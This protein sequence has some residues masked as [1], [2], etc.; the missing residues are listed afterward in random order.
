MRPRPR[1]G[2]KLAGCDLWAVREHANLRHMHIRE[3]RD[4]VGGSP[5]VPLERPWLFGP[6]IAPTAVLSNGVIGGAL[7]YMPRRQGVGPARGAEIIGLLNLPAMIYFLWSP[8]TDFWIRRRSWLMVA[9]T[10]AAAAMLAAFREPSLASHWAVGLMFLSACLGQ[11]IVAGCGGM[12][13]TLHSEAA[14]SFYQSGSLAFGAI[15]VLVL[16]SL[17]E[18]LQLGMLGWLVGAMIALPSLAALAAPEQSAVGEFGMG[19]TLTQIW[20]EFKA[21][22]LR[23]RAIPSTLLIVFPLGSGA[24]I[25]LLPGL[26]V[27][28][29]ISGHQVAW[30]NGVAGALLM[31]AGAVSATLISSEAAE[32]HRGS[33]P[34]RSPQAC[35]LRVAFPIE[36]AWRHF[37]P[38]VTNHSEREQRLRS[39]GIIEMWLSASGHQGHGAVLTLRLSWMWFKWPAAGFCPVRES[40]LGLTGNECLGRSSAC[41]TGNLPLA[42]GLDLESNERQLS[43]RGSA[44]PRLIG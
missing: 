22:F 36:F 39:N 2:L 26:A 14:S 21:T 34:T 5:A 12:M 6:L 23:W 15:A 30:I 31:A 37:T 18:R 24:M 13:G 41:A 42:I 9:A 7:S 16:V 38:S 11:L 17:S 43:G 28:Y 25:Q 1:K 8:V 35:R 33:A 44:T 10:A 29:H 40:G 4:T 32:P 27:D 19:K 3:R 20:R